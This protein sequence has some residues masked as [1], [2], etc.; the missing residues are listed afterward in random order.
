MTGGRA[1]VASLEANGA[2]AVFGIPGVHNLHIYDALIDSSLEHY[3]T[4][5]EQGAGFMAD[6]YARATGKP[7]VCLPITGPGIT[8]MSTPIAQ[9]FSDSSPLVVISSQID[10]HLCDCQKGTLHELKNQLAFTEQITEWN[11]RALTPQQCATELSRAYA[12]LAVRRRRPVHVE[13]PLDVLAAEDDVTL[14]GPGAPLYP[15]LRPDAEEIEKAAALIASS[16]SPVIY[17]GGGALAAGAGDALLRLSAALGAPVILTC[18]GK[19]AVPEDHPAVLGNHLH[20]PLVQGFLEGCDLTI[21]IGTHFGAHNTMNWKFKFPGP[22]IHLDIDRGEFHKNYP[23]AATV[24]SDARLGIEA[25]LKAMPSRQSRGRLDEVPHLKEQ[26]CAAFAKSNAWETQYSGIIR[27]ALGR[28]GILVCDM[29][30]LCYPATRCYPVYEPHTFM[31][32]R[33]FGTLGFALPVAMGAKVGQKGKKVV[34]VAGDGGFMFTCQEL[35]IA[36][37]YNIPVVLVLVNSSSYHVVKR[38]QIRVFGDHRTVDVELRN[39][40]F[41]KMAD[42]FGVWYRQAPDAAQF[43]TS[44]QEALAHNGPVVIEIPFGP[45]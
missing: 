19:G 40:D 4:R 22:I 16:R 39:P 10:T 27:E 23:A 1:V 2:K 15:E 32:P 18:Q 25:L 3:V 13:A 14:P 24:W 20:D 9:A 8:N 41:G 7:G 34:A 35:A 44:L 33:G 6:G 37:Q 11:V 38:N 29:T 21:A 26:V 42:A 28:D 30:A 31:F 36:A 5:H 12:W 17:A 43:E 45:A